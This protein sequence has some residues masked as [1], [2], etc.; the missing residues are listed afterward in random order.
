MI[1]TTLNPQIKKACQLVERSKKIALL[2]PIKP[3]GDSI[4]SA[5]ALYLSLKKIGK[6]PILYCPDTVSE[7]FNYLKQIKEFSPVIKIEDFDLLI[8]VDFAEFDGFKLDRQQIKAKNI[9]LINIDH[10]ITN[11]HFG[12][13]NIVDPTA[14]AACEVVYFLIKELRV[15]LDKDI[16]TALLTGLSTDTGSFQH[17]NTSPRVLN[18]ASILLGRGAK[19][20]KISKEVYHTKPIP[21]LKLWGKA[22]TNLRFD[23][24]T[25][26]AVSVI[27]HDDFHE[28]EAELSDLEGAISLLACVPESKITILLSQYRDQIKGS[29]RTENDKVDVSKLARTLGGGGH[30]KASGFTLDGEIV[31]VGKDWKILL[32]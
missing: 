4:G 16:A 31:K 32:K 15:K 12:D 2:N 5:I 1:E 19:L 13:L 30:R 10:H 28:C 11:T 21:S 14:A 7:R 27:T 25:K 20:I 23:P 17:S 18:I 26:I 24:D 9:P 8:S 6:Q 29:L 22:L 3:D